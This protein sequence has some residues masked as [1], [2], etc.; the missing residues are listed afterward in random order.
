MSDKI[1]IELSNNSALFPYLLTP[2][3][4]LDFGSEA[5]EICNARI[6]L[7]QKPVVRNLRKLYE[8]KNI[9]LP[10]DLQVLQFYDIWLITYAVG[11]VTSGSNLKKIRQLQLDIQ[12]FDAD[13]SVPNVTII[14][15]LPQSKFTKIIDGKMA[16]D[17][18][19][20]VEG[21][22]GTSI[23]S[24]QILH[25]DIISGGGKIVVNGD[26]HCGLNI[27][28]N[29]LSTDITAIGVGNYT[30]TWVLDRTND[31]P[32]LGDQLFVH[33]VL[34]QQDTPYI[35]AKAKVST[36]CT[37]PF[38]FLPL[39]IEGEWNKLHIPLL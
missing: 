27:S 4:Q 19:I 1:I 12:Y 25:T 34:V 21:K 31:N 9:P 3:D 18:D 8:F 2:P 5:I 11:I 30:G 32:L 38:G 10:P 23:S 6:E 14:D 26:I 15:I 37:A 17:V 35:D 13:E 29:V 24:S 16:L 28:F 39:R 33:T 7:G 20:N 36:T 22:A